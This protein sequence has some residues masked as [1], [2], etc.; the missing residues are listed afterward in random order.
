MRGEKVCAHQVAGESCEVEINRLKR[1]TGKQDA[2]AAAGGGMNFFRFYPDK[3]VESVPIKSCEDNYQNL[4]YTNPD[5]HR[6]QL[7]Q[8][9]T[10]NRLYLHQELSGSHTRRCYR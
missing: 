1:P 9:K 2:Y 7:Y 8:I 6:F 5:I 10:G 3:Q 4:G